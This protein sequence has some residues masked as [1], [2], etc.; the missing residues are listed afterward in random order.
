MTRHSGR[1]A[2]PSDDD[3]GQLPGGRMR[4]DKWLWAARF[5]KTRSLAGE[6]IDGGKVQVNGERAKRAKGVAPGDEVRLRQG[7]YEHV[8]TVRALSERRGPA[9]QAQQ[10]Y[11]ETTAS[12]EARERIALQMKAMDMSYAHGAGRPGKVER[13]QIDRARRRD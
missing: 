9:A 2:N 3:D 8:L 11:E 12:R 5:F 6:A 4:L 10:L 13:R 1:T 7:A